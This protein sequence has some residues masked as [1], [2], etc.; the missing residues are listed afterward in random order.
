MRLGSTLL[1][2][3]DAHKQTPPTHRLLLSRL[4]SRLCTGVRVWGWEGG[5]GGDRVSLSVCA[6][7][8]VCASAYAGERSDP[9]AALQ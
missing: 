5:R 7:G 1:A 9:E 3:P 6:R 4:S 8:V 2:E